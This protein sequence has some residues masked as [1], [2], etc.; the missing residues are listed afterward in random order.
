MWQGDVWHP[1][2][3]FMFAGLGASLPIGLG[4]GWFYAGQS[5]RFG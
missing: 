3:A 2:G 4:G 5:A 1:F